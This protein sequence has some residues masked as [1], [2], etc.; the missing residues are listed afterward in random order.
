MQRKTPAARKPAGGAAAAK[1]AALREKESATPQ[2]VSAPADSMMLQMQR[3]IDMLTQDQRNLNNHVSDLTRDYQAIVS[4]MSGF[5]RSFAAQD[6]LMQN[7]INY[8]VAVE[9]SAYRYDADRPF[10]PSTEVQKLITFYQ[11]ISRA[12]YEH[13][14]SINRRAA[15]AANGGRM[16]SAGAY[17]G[18]TSDLSLENKSSPGSSGGP[19][20]PATFGDRENPSPDMLGRPNAQSHGL[21]AE[22]GDSS[23]SSLINSQRQ[24]TFYPSSAL[25]QNAP[26]APSGQH[27][28][29]GNHSTAAQSTDDLYQTAS[30]SDQNQLNNAASNSG[31]PSSK[32]PGSGRKPYKPDWAVPP[33]VL[34]VEDDSVCRT[35]SSKFLEVFGC[36][37][38]VAVDGVSA[39]N[40]MNAE[41]Y[42]LVFMVR[43][44][45]DSATL[46]I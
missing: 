1:A 31:A 41:K 38:D 37:I 22:Y 5:E 12:S 2:P 4:D 43:L 10:T 14:E 46:L 8:L 29:F 3:Q 32:S 30:T 45:N 42:D 18:L 44:I 9:K 34:L 26:A 40:K 39:V 17:A 36:A 11:E 23:R 33:K 24:P 35:L 6:H 27:R 25:D 15:A 21:A 7:M 20:S 28:V 13:F 16:G 19:Y